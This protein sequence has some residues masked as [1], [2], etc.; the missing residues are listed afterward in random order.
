M[1]RPHIALPVRDLDASV[2]FYSAFLGC[3]PTRRLP[4]YAQFLMEEPGLNLA[5]TATS[6]RGAHDGHFGI[7]V[8]TPEAVASALARAQAHNLPVDVEEDTR[9]CYSRQTK[10]WAA[11]PDGRRWEIFYV[12]EREGRGDAPPNEIPMVSGCCAG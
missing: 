3:D 2:A 8:P 10:F 6:E 12:A 7:E 4:G 9:C 11:D 1:T 5:L